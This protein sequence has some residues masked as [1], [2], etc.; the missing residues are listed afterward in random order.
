MSLE[1]EI[2]MSRPHVPSLNKISPP[3]FELNF[4]TLTK[5]S[6]SFGLK[7][8]KTEALIVDF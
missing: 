2:K 8:L 1:I 5:T 6:K 4:T 7:D 3:V